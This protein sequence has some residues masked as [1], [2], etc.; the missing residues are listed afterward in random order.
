MDA[1][2]LLETRASNPKLG[3]PA[4]D[5]ATLRRVLTAA[6]RAPDH[7]L[8]R[9]WKVFVVQ[10]TQRQRLGE[11]LEEAERAR[12]PA[13]T[14]EALAKARG[15]PLRA[16]LILVVAACPKPDPKVPEVEQLISAGTLAHNIGLGLHALGYAT[17]WRT[18]A[19]RSSAPLV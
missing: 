3:E 2:E 1:L 11:V 17:M 10:G 7:K 9:P 13:A 12:N 15:K 16:P 19:P 4:P 14:P 6:L 18:G 8:L 5:E